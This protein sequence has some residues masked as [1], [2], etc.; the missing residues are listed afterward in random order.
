MGAG[1]KSAMTIS[2]GRAFQAESMAS[3][4][5]LWWE[6]GGYFC[7]ASR[8]VVWEPGG[9]GVRWPWGR[10]GGGWTRHGEDFG[11][12]LCGMETPGEF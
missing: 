4:R 10:G 11:F 2:E 5:V 12:S 1:R 3:T 6:L 7:E 8:S 9:S